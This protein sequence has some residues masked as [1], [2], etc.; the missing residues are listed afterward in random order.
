MSE[1]I[2]NYVSQT[3]LKDDEYS[4]PLDISDILK[5]CKE[6]NQL[7]WKIQNQIENILEY[8][9]EDSIKNNLIKPES[10]PHIKNFLI[11]ITKN[12]YFG[13]AVSQAEECIKIINNFEKTNIE[14]TSN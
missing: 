13:D 12:A 10:L 2:N 4:I 5:I 14:K 8:G 7:G 9:V 11:Q 1:Q 6:Y 3:L